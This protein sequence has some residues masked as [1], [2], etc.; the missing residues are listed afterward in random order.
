FDAT[1]TTSGLYI[2]AGAGDDSIFMGSGNDTVYGGTG[3]DTIRGGAG[4]DVLFGDA[5]NDTLDGGAGNDA[6][7]G[8]NDADTF[9]L[10]GTNFGADTITGGE[11]GT[12][13]DT[14]D[15]S[16]VTGNI[17]VTFSGAEAG[18]LT[19]STGG[20]ASF[21]QI[22]A[23]VTG[24]GDDTINAAANTANAS[25]AT[26]AGN[27][28]ITGGSGNETLD[29]GSGN[30]M[31]SGGGGNDS[32]L[33][34]AGNDTLIGGDGADS[35][36]G[37]DDRDTFFVGASD[38]VDGGEGGDDYDVLDL[39]S[40]GFAATNIIYD[41]LNHENGTVEFLDAQ[42]NVI[43]K[44][45]FHN[46]EK[47]IACFTPGTMILTSEGKVAIE[48]LAEGDL[49][50]TRDNGFQ[51]I[52]W[53]GRR[54]LSAADLVAA[55]QFNPVQIAVGALGA[56]LPERTMQV[57]PQHRM[58]INTPRAE[59][60][61]GEAEVLAAAV[62]LVGKAGITRITPREVCYIHLLFDEHQLICADGAWSESF[63][64]GQ[65]TLAGMDAAQRQ[66]VFALFPALQTGAS[67][68]AARMMLKSRE[69]HILLHA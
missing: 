15:T 56:G 4:N 27:D 18:G 61:F 17:N 67:Y 14:I 9:L 31:L 32:I 34:G 53:I 1:A 26:G 47:V 16:G 65:H 2:G 62:H 55:P 46:I 28:T 63:Q 54:Q 19:S 22:E 6:L 57:S 20:T 68:P 51:P 33:G 25:Y 3:A 36:Y 37:G 39:T 69:A 58:L 11:G 42:G 64:P 41:P 59:L 66:E 35:L 40:Y 49:V 44:M 45:T 10:T 43:G 7:N 24:T 29:G 12:D 52:R 23:I 60:L 13:A 21:T 30:D 38:S 8:G 48:T 50:L 5:G